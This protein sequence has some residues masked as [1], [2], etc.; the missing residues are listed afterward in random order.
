MWLSF[1][2]RLV[3]RLF[4]KVGPAQ[5]KALRP[6]RSKFIRGTSRRSRLKIVDIV[7]VCAGLAVRP[8]TLVDC[9]VHVDEYLEFNDFLDG[10][11]V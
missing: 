4:H 9:L 5:A 2:R 10:E 3:G 11:P 6:K 1:T 8:G 7:S